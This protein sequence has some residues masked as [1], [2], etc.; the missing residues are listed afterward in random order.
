[1]DLQDFIL[2]LSF[3]PS[4]GAGLQPVL[5]L[6]CWVCNPTGLKSHTY[7]SYTFIVAASR[8]LNQAILTSCRSSSSSHKRLAASPT[9]CPPR[10][11]GLAFGHRAVFPPCLA[12]ARHALTGHR[13]SQGAQP[14]G[15][16][17]LD[18]QSYAVI[19]T[20]GRDLDRVPVRSLAR[21][22]MTGNEA[23][24]NCSLEDK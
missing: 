15:W 24:I 14:K 10:P 7:F 18:S 9:F 8:N 20:I 17:K 5:N 19:S 16:D 23:S 21:L 12:A 13:S 2:W 1:M 3:H 11:G 4:A 6:Y 22:E